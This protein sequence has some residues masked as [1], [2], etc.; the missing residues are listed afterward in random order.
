[1]RDVLLT[2]L[3]F[4]LVAGRPGLCSPRHDGCDVGGPLCRVKLECIVDKGRMAD[5]RNGAIGSCSSGL[6]PR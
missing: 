5:D 3:L 1:M 2:D 4:A 6:R